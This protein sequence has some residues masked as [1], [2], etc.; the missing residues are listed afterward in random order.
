M[1]VL[2]SFLVFLLLGATLDAAP[3]LVRDG[4]PQAEI[5]VGEKPLRSVRLAAAEFQESIEKISGARLPIRFSSKGDLPVKV[6]IGES[7]FTR[8]QGISTDDLKYG[9]YRIK[10]GGDWMVLVGQDTEFVP[11]EPWAKSNN[12]RV[13]NLQA[14]WEKASGT[15]YG[16]PNGGMYK[17]RGRL[18]AKT[19]LPD[20]VEVGRNDRFDFWAYDERGSFNA[21]C[22]FLRTLGMR[23]YLPGELG[24]VVPSMRSIP[25]PPM[26]E[27]VRPDFEVRQFSGRFATLDEETLK[28][29]LRLGVRSLYGLMIAHG[30]DTMTHPDVLKSMHP[31]W[32]ALYG[33]KRDTET[34]KRLNHLCYSNEELFRET[35][36]WARAQ[37]DVYDYESVSIMPPDAYIAICQC[38][39]CEGKEIAEMGARGKLSNHVW[40]FVNRVAREVG[41]THPGK[42]IVCCAYGANTQP[43]TNIDKLEPNV[44]VVIVGGRRPRNS[45][46]EQREEIRKLREGW[47]EKTT[48]PI[49]IF[50]NYPFTAR[51]TYLPAFVARTIGD[52]INATKGV[53]R[54]EDIWLSYPRK[55]DDPAIGFDHFQ[56]YFTARM[57]WGGK[58][59]NAE[60]L[61]EEY[62]QLFYGA[63][64][65][66]M[67]AFFD[68]CELNYQAMDD[69]K[70]KVDKALALFTS[71]K[72]A[73]PGDSIHGQRLGLIDRFLDALRSKAEQLGQKRGPVAKLRTVWEPK[74]PI[75]IDGKL[76]D[77]YWSECP[78]SSVGGLRELQTGAQPTFGTRVMAA[79]DKGGN[80]LYFGIR[81]EERKGEPLNVATNKREDQSLWYGDA[82][83]ILLD[84]DSHRYYQIAVNPAGALVDADR[85]ADKS[86]WFRWESQVEVATH[87]AEDHWTVEIRIPVTDDE[88]DPL[89][90]VIG[91][92]PSQ[93]LPWHFNICRQRIRE[94]GSEFSALSP[95]GKASFHVPLKFAHFYDGRSH[96]F[97]VDETV[98]DF[99]IELGKA[100]KLHKGR[101]YTPA[102]E[103]F[104][105]LAG[106]KGIT[107]FQKSRCLDRAADCARNLKDLDRASELAASIPI[108]AVAKKVDMENRMARRDMEGI[109]A[110]HGGEHLDEWPF[111]QVGEAAFYRGLAQGAMK[112]GREAEKDLRLVLEF[113]PDT[114]RQLSILRLLA[115]NEE[116]VLGNDTKALDY[117]LQMVGS[118]TN[119]NGA[120]YFY[121][122]QGAAQL[123]SRLG[124]HQEAIEVLDKVDA[125]KLPGS[126]RGAM[127]LA[128]TRALSAADRKQEAIEAGEEVLK[129]PGVQKAH[130][131][132]A[133]DLLEKLKGN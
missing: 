93:S 130:E 69:S 101:K 111:W 31:D 132:I 92:K 81:C 7:D 124:R 50:E 4:Q 88:N 71:A 9:A 75:V 30:M 44:Q 55:L 37:F 3:F 59:A 28:W 90:Q 17:E 113:T 76:D 70:E 64:G 100:E 121:G 73:V 47:I 16:A 53:S 68:Y 14:A 42:K 25:L 78:S 34:G 126:W 91:R 54:G 89:N 117:Y 65:S 123:L 127:F 51:G 103:A 12:D 94:N 24:E 62:C 36:R 128:R 122:I 20:D 125:A 49:M 118:K 86:A 85:G 13:K 8:R 60:G 79:W 110:A 11:H 22:G 33:G 131:Q 2:H 120:D 35:V 26:D 105:S 119:T 61:L 106:Q 74:E 32:F 97:D 38:A 72:Q 6:Y 95:T 10:T 18:P 80:N 48:N 15:P 96:S 39:L 21:V 114:R 63:A 66:R 67:K 58:E 129:S 83:E 41:K 29:T 109:V 133:R 5:L 115:L 98:T 112:Q 104:L 107:D 84:T 52:S 99:L 19:G 108:E 27:V 45:Q 23:W 102:L 46:P 82:I 116:R 87:V 40:D 77:L 56:V 1:K 57:W 43:P